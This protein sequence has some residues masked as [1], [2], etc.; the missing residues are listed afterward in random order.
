VRSNMKKEELQ[1]AIAAARVEWRA[2]RSDKLSRKNELGIPGNDKSAVRR[3]RLY[4]E[5][6][7]RQR[8]FA[9]RIVHLERRMNRMRAR[10]K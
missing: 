1:K 4:R 2:A 6:K 10:E 9:A 8:R 7:K 3:D 5:L